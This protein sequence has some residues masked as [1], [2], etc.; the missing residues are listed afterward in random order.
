MVCEIARFRYDGVTVRMMIH[1]QLSA[2]IQ[3]HLPQEPGVPIAE[4]L[5]YL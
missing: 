2:L 1:W 5:T 4:T 3:K